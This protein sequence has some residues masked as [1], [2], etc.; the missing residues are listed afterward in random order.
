MTSNSK[1]PDRFTIRRNISGS[2]RFDKEALKRIHGCISETEDDVSIT[3]E[4]HDGRSVRGR[5]ISSLIEDSIFYASPIQ[6]IRF[7]RSKELDLSVRLSEEYFSPVYFDISGDRN[8]VLSIEQNLINQFCGCKEWYGPLSPDYKKDNFFNFIFR[9]LSICVISLF[10]VA[11]TFPID[12]YPHFKN[13][14]YAIFIVLLIGIVCAV[15]F[16][17]L[18]KAFPLIV[19][20]IGKGEAN[21]RWRSWGLGLFFSVAILGIAWNKIILPYLFSM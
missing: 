21:N 13:E 2:F 6:E 15:L 3:I 17:T 8:S 9:V 16:F 1:Q 4:T 10:L 19:F 18:K 12:A 14:D 5:N 11:F 20:D 7:D